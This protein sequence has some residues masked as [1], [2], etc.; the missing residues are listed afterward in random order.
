[1]H[2]VLEG[3]HVFS[4]SVRSVNVIILFVQKLVTSSEKDAAPA[5][6]MSLKAVIVT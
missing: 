5:T 4:W 6:G 1:M 3:S 2:K